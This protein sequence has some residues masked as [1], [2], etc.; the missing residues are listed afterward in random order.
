MC[1]RTEAECEKAARS[2]DRRTYLWGFEVLRYGE[3]P[4]SAGAK[5]A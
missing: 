4:F 1:L 2:T 3:G 5:T